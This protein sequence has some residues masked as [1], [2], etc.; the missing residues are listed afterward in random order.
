M[1]WPLPNPPKGRRDLAAPTP[2]PRERSH[3]E[4]LYD[5]HPRTGANI[6]VF[7]ADC[8]LE[9]FGRS[10]AGWFWWPRRRGCSSDGS[11]PW[12]PA[13]SS[14]EGAAQHPLNSA[15]SALEAQASAVRE[16]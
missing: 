11:A 9:T 10:G 12:M 13:A 2:D 8:A 14:R 1:A 7:Y 15:E 4:P 6:E 16:I 3:N 5:I